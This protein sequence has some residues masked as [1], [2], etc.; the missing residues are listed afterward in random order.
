M[1]EQYFIKKRAFL[2]PFLHVIGWLIYFSGDFDWFFK[3][4]WEQEDLI[5][6]FSECLVYISTF[7]LFYY[8]TWPFCFQKRRYF[9]AVPG[10]ILGLIFF[11]VFR[12]FIQEM[13]MPFFFGFSNYV[14]EL[15]PWIYIKD[16]FWRPFQLILWSSAIYLLVDKLEKDKRN[17]QLENSKTEAQLA[18]LRSQINPHF[19]FNMLS[20]LHTK[21]YLKD[22]DLAHSILQL[23]DLLRYSTEKKDEKGAKLSEEMR[24]LENYLDL[25]RKR[26]G[27]RCFVDYQV[28]G[29]IE[30]QQ[31]EPLIFQPF[32]ENAFKHGVYTDEKTPVVINF[33]I[34]KNRLAFVC[35]N[36]INEH[37]RDKGNGIGLENVRQRLQLLYPNDH[38]LKL[39]NVEGYFSVFLTIQFK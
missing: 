5:V 12:Y 33:K 29:T 34:D 15:T 7:Y 31:I 36:K 22:E 37:T 13:M 6:E 20:Y 38:E 2:E 39:E 26:F 24:H 21:A 14:M 30:N 23:S 18:F 27:T 8:L 19:L 11:M 3:N 32:I 16:N 17:Q 25:Y 35:K 4:E 28:D 9:T 1:K 10:V